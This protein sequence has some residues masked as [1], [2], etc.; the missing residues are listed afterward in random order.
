MADYIPRPRDKQLLTKVTTVSKE[1]WRH[2]K[3]HAEAIH[4]HHVRAAE[5]KN[6]QRK[7]DDL[8][9][10]G[11][12]NGREENANFGKLIVSRTK[13]PMGTREKAKRTEN[14]PTNQRTANKTTTPFKVLNRKLL[15]LNVN[16]PNFLIKS[17]LL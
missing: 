2:F 5:D 13:S 1:K 17:C 14:N 8:S 4:D 16:R 15:T 6:S 3:T 12:G 7:N 9:H 11:T 10:K